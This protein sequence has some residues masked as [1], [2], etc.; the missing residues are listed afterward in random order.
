MGLWREYKRSLVNQAPM[1]TRRGLR[2]LGKHWVGGK[3]IQDKITKWRQGSDVKEDSGPVHGLASSGEC[4][5]GD[6]GISS[7]VLWFMSSF[8]TNRSVVTILYVYIVMAPARSD[9]LG[10][11]APA[12]NVTCWSN[13]HL[14]QMTLQPAVARLQPSLWYFPINFI[15]GNVHQLRGWC[16]DPITFWPWCSIMPQQPSRM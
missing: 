12:P 2:K 3:T 15:V 10:H 1:G 14:F 11:T 6:K 5:P 4:T 13:Y 16:G 7:P 8:G 9:G